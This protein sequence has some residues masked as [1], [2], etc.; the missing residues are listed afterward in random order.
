MDE[1]FKIFL[2]NNGISIIAPW[3]GE[4]N[5]V[6][7]KD[8]VT[9]LAALHRKLEATRTTLL[10]ARE[11]RQEACNAGKLPDFLPE[12]KSIREGNWKC[13]PIP[14]DLLDRRVEITGPVSKKMLI[15]GLNSGAKVYMADFEDANSPTFHNNIEGQANLIHAANRTLSFQDP[16]GKVYSVK[17]QPAVLMVRPRGWHLVEA[18]FLV[19]GKP[20]SGSLFDFGLYFFHN[21]KTLHQK[22][23]GPYFYLPK[24]ESH[25]EAR[26]WNEAFEFSENYLGLGKVIRATVLIETIYGAFE[27]D[28]ILYELR[29]HSA[30]LN[31]GRWDYIFSIIKKF[32]NHKQFLMGDRA[33][34]TMTQPFMDAYVKLLIKTCHRRGVHAMGG[35]AAQIPIRDNA[36]ANTAAENKVRNDKLREVKAGH[37]G[38][39]VA[40][41]GL[42]PIAMEIFNQHMPRA[43]QLDVLREDVSIT[44]K[45]LLA[46]PQGEITEI[47]F[48]GNLNVAVLYL[49]AWLN[50]N[51]CVPIHNLM[52]DLATAEIAR[53][54]V[55]QWIRHGAK[56][57]NGTLISRQYAVDILREETLKITN[58]SPKLHLAEFLLRLILNS[59]KFVEFMS[60]AAYPD[61]C[62]LTNTKIILSKL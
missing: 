46:V 22:G 53:S 14:V 7:T 6:L 25:K 45:D 31:C 48:R 37:D 17:N 35:M 40:H 2:R 43:N 33:Q 5:E 36:E 30:G 55:S 1:G 20:I 4:C 26:L 21:A 18:H 54:Q 52:E 38:T 11:T 51:G 9:F 10:Q 15:N 32:I 44:A 8:S 13:A 3:F 58:G 57:T 59:D 24:M 19:D 29:D 28:E 16:N 39:W 34:I 41:P 42:I 62:T 60:L 61:I 23:S 12:T 56:L 50:G 49:E 47:G 27:M